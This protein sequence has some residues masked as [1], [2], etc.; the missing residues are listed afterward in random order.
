MPFL[1]LSI[2]VLKGENAP[3]LTHVPRKQG[4]PKISKVGGGEISGLISFQLEGGTGNEVSLQWRQRA[5][6][7]DPIKAAREFVFRYLNRLLRDRTL[8]KLPLA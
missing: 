7:D 1:I 8:C 4:P 2:P 3:I 5:Y 6:F